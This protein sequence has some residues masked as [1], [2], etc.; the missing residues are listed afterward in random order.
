MDPDTC[1]FEVKTDEDVYKEYQLEITVSKVNQKIVVDDII[2]A[3]K[4]AGMVSENAGDL[5][6][7]LV[8]TY[9]GSKVFVNYADYKK[10]KLESGQSDPNTSF[11]Y[12][13]KK[14]SYSYD[15]LIKTTKDENGKEVPEISKSALESSFVSTGVSISPVNAGVYRL[16]VSLKDVD[17]KNYAEPAYVY[18]VISVC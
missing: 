8:K 16:E 3:G 17:G 5:A 9:D 1:G 15:E 12:A 13:W 18:F 2:A 10:A 4:S 7:A 6:D 14:S 11:S